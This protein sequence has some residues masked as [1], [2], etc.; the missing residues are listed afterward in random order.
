M[1]VPGGTM[2]RKK[3]SAPAA[4]TETVRAIKPG[5]RAAQAKILADDSLYLPRIVRGVAITTT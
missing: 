3:A 5:F 2:T 4:T 1:S